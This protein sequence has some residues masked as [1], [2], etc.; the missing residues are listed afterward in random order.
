MDDIN[1]HMLLTCHQI[2]NEARL[3]PF[4]DNEFGFSDDKIRPERG[5]AER[6]QEGP[7]LQP[8]LFLRDLVPAQ[9]R[10]INSL[11]LSSS[12]MDTLMERDIQA[13]PNLRRLRLR[14]DWYVRGVELPLQQLVKTLDG[15]FTSSGIEMF[16][17]LRLES[18]EIALKLKVLSTIVDSVN[19]MRKDIITWVDGKQKRLL[20]VGQR[21][22]KQDQ[23][24][25]F[26]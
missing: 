13:L 9:S 8:L 16:A 7:W 17:K 25:R 2:Y 19:L 1:L 6:D 11:Y 24:N 21:A 5:P 10:S 23:A 22:I 12:M 18:V 4:K 14:L 26:T 15:H 3:V 20:R